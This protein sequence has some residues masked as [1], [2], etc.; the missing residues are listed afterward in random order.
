MLV[1][2]Y[3]HG[4][5][6][7][8]DNGWYIIGE[9]NE[10]IHD[11]FVD[12]KQNVW[13]ATQDNGAIKFNLKKKTVKKYNHTEGLSAN[14]VRIILQDRWENMWFGTSGGGWSRAPPLQ[15]VKAAIYSR[16]YALSL[17]V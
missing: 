17:L 12:N 7:H 4:L 10:I 1:G 15:V 2:T 3:G 11:V 6:V 9:S 13:A 14:N 16:D 5:N 8:N